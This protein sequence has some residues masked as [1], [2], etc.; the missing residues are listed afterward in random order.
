MKIAA[1][2]RILLTFVLTISVIIVGGSLTEFQV[3]SQ[4]L[5]QNLQAERQGAKEPKFSLPIQCKLGQDCFIQ[6]YS[7]RDSGKAE[8]DWGCGRLTYDGHTGTDFAIPNQ[9]AMARGVQVLAA[10]KGKVLRIR[11]GVNDLPLKDRNDPRIKGQ[12]CGNGVVVEHGNSWQ[13]QYCHLRRGSVVVKPGDLVNS[14]SQLG[15]VGESG[16]ASFPHVHFEIRHQNKVVDPFMGET[17]GTRCL[18]KPQSLW[19]NPLAYISTGFIDAGFTNLLPTVEQAEQGNMSMEKLT[20]QSNALIFWIRA[21]GVLEGDE[22]QYQILAPDQSVFSD[23]VQKIT[24]SSKSWFSYTGKRN[25]QTLSPGEW[26]GKYSLIR[27]GNPVFQIS[28]K[29][30]VN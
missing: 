22:E 23:R 18:R 15:L 1:I 27:N 25:T 6:L 8:I 11:D 10:A 24:K 5:A 16:M 2:A 7:D 20:K 21:Y 28:R 4:N 19:Q 13:T 3:S 9:A 14:G 12:E 17:V 26:Q 30:L 29:L